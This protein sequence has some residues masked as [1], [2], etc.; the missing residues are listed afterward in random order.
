M[1]QPQALEESIVQKAK[2]WEQK[3][4]QEIKST[5]IGDG[6][7]IVIFLAILFILFLTFITVAIDNPVY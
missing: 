2:A 5:K 6:Y 7:P 3:N 1:K 4:D